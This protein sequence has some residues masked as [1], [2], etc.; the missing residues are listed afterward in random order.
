[1]EEPKEKLQ[2]IAADKCIGDYKRHVF[3]CTGPDCCT[4]E[5]GLAAW[6]TLK[7]ELKARGLSLSKGPN[8]CYR[9]KVNC[10]RI[11]SNGPIV[12]VYPE[13]TWYCGMS[14]ERIPHFVDQHLV[15]GLPVSDWIFTSNP[16]PAKA[17]R[18][19]A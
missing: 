11:C 4:P 14:A 5:V 17:S 9:T 3:L 13:G 2:A 16:L 7:Q 18:E 19:D 15:Q 8:A 12:V 10:L 1:M 6:E